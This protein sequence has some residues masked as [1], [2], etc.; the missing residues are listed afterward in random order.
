LRRFLLWSLS[1][2]LTSFLDETSISPGYATSYFQRTFTFGAYKVMLLSFLS[3]KIG[4][5]FRLI[6]PS[7]SLAFL[8]RNT[9]LPLCSINFLP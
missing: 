1:K 2:I 3:K 7:S 6:S 5:F 8:S 4:Y 9:I